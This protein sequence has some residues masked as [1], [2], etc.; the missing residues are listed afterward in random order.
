[1]LK[2]RYQIIHQR[3]EKM[4]KACGQKY[5][6]IKRSRYC[7]RQC[8]LEVHRRACYRYIE[9]TRAP[10]QQ[11]TEWPCKICQK[12]FSPKT[13]ANCFCSQRCREVSR[14]KQIQSDRALD[15]KR[16]PTQPCYICK[17]MFQ[18]VWPRHNA[19][20]CGKKCSKKY[21]NSPYQRQKQRFIEEHGVSVWK[22]YL[23][24]HNER[25]RARR[26]NRE[27]ELS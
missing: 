7:G 24:I 16:E 14:M 21:R 6:G 8:R 27:I 15:R 19:V 9:R 4:C 13:K 25:N 11:L 18:P 5:M 17:K 23:Q 22:T 2:H 26:K 3:T 12:V 1:M 10:K 20:T